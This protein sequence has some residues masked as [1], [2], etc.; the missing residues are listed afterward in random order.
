MIK[1]YNQEDFK[2]PMAKHK[3]ASLLNFIK[4]EV[5]LE[6]AVK[7]FNGVYDERNFTAIFTADSFKKINSVESAM[8][9]LSDF[10]EAERASFDFTEDEKETNIHVESLNIIAFKFPRNFQIEKSS[11][12]T[13]EFIYRN[14]AFN[15][16]D[17]GFVFDIKDDEDCFKLLKLIGEYCIETKSPEL[18]KN[19]VAFLETL[20]E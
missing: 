14:K 5:E 3:T 19:V 15:N 18:Y 11:R 8:Q 7:S 12:V 2:M 20:Y 17:D 16:C 9:V 6:K 13:V 1:R 10:F 4:S